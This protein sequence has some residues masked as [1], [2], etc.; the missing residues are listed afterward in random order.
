MVTAGLGRHDEALHHFEAAHALAADMRGRPL[1]ALIQTEQARVLFSTGATAEARHLLSAA[2]MTTTALGMHAITR[3][4]DALVASASGSDV[5]APHPNVPERGHVGRAQI[6]S[7]RREGSLWTVTAGGTVLRCK[8]SKGLQYLA[9]LLRNPGKSFH[10]AELMALDDRAPADARG[11]DATELEHLGMH[12]GAPQVGE[13]I[14]DAKALVAYRRR[15]E[16][17]SSEMAEATRFNDLARSTTLQAE[18]DVLSQAL[19]SAV[20]F[21][22]RARATGSFVERARLNVTRAI[23]SAIR[24]IGEGLPDLQRHLDASIQTGTFCR[25]TPGPGEAPRW[26]L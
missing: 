19:L 20:G 12:V 13:P 18:I 6:A 8:S 1:V 3:K 9:Q 25:Y 4:I 7:L 5:A 24:R 10:V 11:L 2:R 26:E 21:G 23:R 14:V 17:L 16:D 22:G 15:L